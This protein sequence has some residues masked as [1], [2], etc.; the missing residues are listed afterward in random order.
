MR[1]NPN[2][3]VASLTLSGLFLLLFAASSPACRKAGDGEANSGKSLD[4][5]KSKR[6]PSLEYASSYQPDVDAQGQLVLPGT[7]APTLAWSG[8]QSV[9]SSSYEVIPVD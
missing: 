3:K 5:D 4:S 7:S 6:L 9:G 2:Q 1:R 8:R